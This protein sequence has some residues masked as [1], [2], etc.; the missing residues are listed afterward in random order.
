MGNKEA[1]EREPAFHGSEVIGSFAL[2][3]RLGARRSSMI[4]EK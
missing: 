3:A 2:S 1:E 4:I